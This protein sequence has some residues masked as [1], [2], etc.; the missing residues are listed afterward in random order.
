[1]EIE[2]IPSV[3]ACD[4]GNTNIRMA[5]VSGEEVSSVVIVPSDDERAIAA[6]IKAAW[7]EIPEPKAL[8]ACSVNASAL[9]HLERAAMAAGA[10]PVQVVGRDLPLPIKTTLK[11]PEV[12]GTDRLCAAVAAYDRL[13][14][15]CVVA[16]F[17][18][19][20][21][22]D[23][24]DD[25]GVFQGGAIFPG[26]HLSAAALHEHTAQLPQVTIEA[27]TWAFGGDTREAILAGLFASARGALQQLVEA[28]ATALNHW[29]LVI[30]TGGDAAAVVGELEE[31]SLVQAIV[32][33]LVLRGV[34]MA[35]YNAL[36]KEE[37]E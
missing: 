1:M 25:G 35:Y 26:L 17:G 20:V 7:D 11:H 15:A 10:P 34:A 18:T 9:A 8:A 27:P 2:E 13:G 6:A 28:Y 30:A 24:V 19:A 22:I 23:C 37:A 5:C 21:T 33:D 31:S 29:P 12:V 32:P 36:T 4:V 14:A 16:D 3:L